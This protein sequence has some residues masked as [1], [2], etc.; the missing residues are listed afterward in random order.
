[1][2]TTYQTGLAGELQAEEWLIRNRGMKTLERRYR[3]KAGEIDLIMAEG[4]TVVFVEVKTRIRAAAGIGMLAV[5]PAKQRRISNAAVL[6]LMRNRWLDRP[7]RFDVV[8]V[9]PDHILHIPN[10]FQSEGGMFF[11]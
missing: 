11:A 6:Y 8:E 5:N 2:K 4:N 7:A 10:A 1:M 3:T 9:R